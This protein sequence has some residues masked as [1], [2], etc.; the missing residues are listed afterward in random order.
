MA[1]S[2]QA[3]IESR[4]LSESK[5][6]IKD[7]SPIE[8]MKKIGEFERYLGTWEGTKI[9]FEGIFQKPYPLEGESEARLEFAQRTLQNM[10]EEFHRRY[11]K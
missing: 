11:G 6:N 7:L 3:D 9:M 2:D 10:Y 5:I 4:I 1:V 8:L